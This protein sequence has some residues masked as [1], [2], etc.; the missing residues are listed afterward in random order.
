MSETNHKLILDV[1]ESTIGVN[2]G[3]LPKEE[4]FVENGLLDSLDALIFIFALDKKIGRKVVED[5]EID[6]GLFTLERLSGL[7]DRRP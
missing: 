6:Y 4:N 2:P 5:H 7:M 1:L 3:H